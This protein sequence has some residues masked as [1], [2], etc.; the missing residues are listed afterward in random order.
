MRTNP[1]VASR[2]VYQKPKNTGFEKLGRTKFRRF[3][4]KELSVVQKRN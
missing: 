2:E 3:G 4:V 1:I